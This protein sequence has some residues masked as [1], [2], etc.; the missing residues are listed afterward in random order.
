ME[1]APTP[2]TGAIASESQSGNISP[3]YVQM[4]AGANLSHQRKSDEDID[5]SFLEGNGDEEIDVLSEEHDEPPYSGGKE[6]KRK[7]T[8]Y[9]GVREDPA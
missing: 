1:H 5:D 3:T 6:G 7:A 2:V 9:R 4:L 8:H